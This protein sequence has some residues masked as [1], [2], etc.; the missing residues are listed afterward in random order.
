MDIERGEDGGPSVV[1]SRE[2]LPKKNIIDKQVMSK[3]PL[4]KLLS[5]SFFLPKASSN[6]CTRERL[7][8]LFDPQYSGLEASK[9]VCPD[10]RFDTPLAVLHD[11]VVGL[12][13][14]KYGKKLFHYD[15][16]GNY[17]YYVYILYHAFP[18]NYK[19]LFETSNKDRVQYSDRASRVPSSLKFPNLNNSIRESE[20]L[21][22][23]S[24]QDLI[25]KQN[26]I[27]IA[28]KKPKKPVRRII[29][30][31]WLVISKLNRLF[32]ALKR[33]ENEVSEGKKKKFV[34]DLE[35]NT[36]LIE[37]ISKITSSRIPSSLYDLALRLN[38]IISTENLKK[39]FKKRVN[40]QVD[41]GT[42]ELKTSFDKNTAQQY[43]NACLKAHEEKFN[44]YLDMFCR[45]Y[46]CAVNW[47][48]WGHKLIEILPYV[49]HGVF[50]FKLLCCSHEPTNFIFWNK[51][52]S[53]AILPQG[54]FVFTKMSLD[55]I[56]SLNG[57]E[58]NDV[59]QFVRY[60]RRASTLRMMEDSSVT[61]LC[62]Q[63]INSTSVMFFRYVCAKL[64]PLPTPLRKTFSEAVCDFKGN[65]NLK[66]VTAFVS[67][68]VEHRVG[69]KLPIQF[70]DIDNIT[71][72]LMN[73]K[74][75]ESVESMRAFHIKCTAFQNTILSFDLPVFVA[76]SSASLYP[77]STCLNNLKQ[78]KIFMHN[79]LIAIIS[80]VGLANQEDDVGTLS[81]F[82]YNY[83][84][85]AEFSASYLTFMLQVASI[86]QLENIEAPHLATALVSLIEE[87]IIVQEK[88]QDSLLIFNHKEEILSRCNLIINNAKV[89]PE[90]VPRSNLSDIGSGSAISER[91][92]FFGSLRKRLGI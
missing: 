11:V 6:A 38:V 14:K 30:K 84:R 41:A 18:D 89:S 74:A 66:E 9:V 73:N 21:S 88:R 17:R 16:Y 5:K 52:F 90:T 32:K 87:G 22:T 65:F 68:C 47:E 75:L 54:Q 83:L 55:N 53:I 72:A 77:T 13:E 45:K 58:E 20:I 3:K 2:K 4:Y 78:D 23:K 64:M 26:T 19:K 85:K 12:F 33:V 69:R 35:V 82:T 24:D 39:R 36:R 62:I 34:E 28:P 29:Q 86:Y 59:N 61:A 1:L 8:R 79:Y 50:R 70:S 37:E 25:A 92:S 63:R 49:M 48:G 76:Q 27:N 80:S 57:M 71:I 44:T 56:F 10:K 46:N 91:M 43:F 40:T 7:R 31:T 42:A 81:Q 60:C 67:A 51:I 15:V